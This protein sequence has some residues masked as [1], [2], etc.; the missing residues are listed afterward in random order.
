MNPTYYDSVNRCTVVHS[1]YYPDPKETKPTTV[2]VPKEEETV[3]EEVI[4]KS[5]NKNN[6]LGGKKEVQ[7]SEENILET[8]T[9]LFSTY[10]LD[11]N[12]SDPNFFKKK[13]QSYYH[14]NIPEQDMENIFENEIDVS[15]SEKEK[16]KLM[17]EFQKARLKYE[18]ILKKIQLAGLDDSNSNIEY[19]DYETSSVPVYNSTQCDVTAK[20]STYV[21]MQDMPYYFSQ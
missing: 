21:G 19:N 17:K 15:I 3:V 7:F 5:Q 8:K 1:L 14:E 9:P 10:F 11:R 16:E 4:E 20:Q 6:L 12:E 18:E 2:E 13:V